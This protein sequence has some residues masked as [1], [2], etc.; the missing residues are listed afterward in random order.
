MN[1]CGDKPCPTCPWRK[2]ST[3]GGADITGFSIV[4]MRR[5]LD[6]VPLSGSSHDGFYKVMACHHSKEGLEYACAGY[7]AQHGFQN[8]NVR[9]LAAQGR[10]DINKI[11]DNCSEL[12]LYP[13]FHEMLAAYERALAPNNSN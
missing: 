6:T 4:K 1:L 7:I 2:E 10:I 5:L 11:V 12:N 9:L 3:V 13:N 8:I